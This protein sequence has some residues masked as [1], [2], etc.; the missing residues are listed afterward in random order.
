METRPAGL[1][2]AFMN[3]ELSWPSGWEAAEVAIDLVIISQMIILCNKLSV[4]PIFSSPHQLKI[5]PFGRTQDNSGEQTKCG[6][7]FK[8]F[9]CSCV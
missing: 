2:H 3:S 6:F 8:L 7:I 5:S 9:M 1:I 4:S